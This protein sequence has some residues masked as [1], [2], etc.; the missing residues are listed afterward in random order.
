[1][2][3]AKWLTMNEVRRLLEMP[4]MPNFVDI[5]ED[6]PLSPE[7]FADPRPLLTLGPEI[8]FAGGATIFR[9]ERL[10]FVKCCLELSRI[11]GIDAVIIGYRLSKLCQLMPNNLFD[12]YIIARNQINLRLFDADYA[13]VILGRPDRNAEPGTMPPLKDDELKLLINLAKMV[14]IEIDLLAQRMQ[15]LVVSSGFSFFACTEF[16]ITQIQGGEKEAWAASCALTGRVGGIV[17]QLAP[18]IELPSGKRTTW[19][20]QLLSRD[21]DVYPL[22]DLAYPDRVFYTRAFLK[23]KPF[24]LGPLIRSEETLE[25][26]LDPDQNGPWYR[27]LA[28]DGEVIEFGLIGWQARADARP[29]LDGRDALIRLSELRKD[30][31]QRSGQR[32]GWPDMIR[33]TQKFAEAMNDVVLVVGELNGEVVN[34]VMFDELILR[35]DPQATPEDQSSLVRRDGRWPNVLRI[36]FTAKDSIAL[37]EE[38]SRQLGVVTMALIQVRPNARAPPA[39]VRGPG[40]LL[41]ELPP[42]FT[43]TIDEKAEMLSGDSQ[44]MGRVLSRE[45]F[46]VEFGP[47]GNGVVYVQESLVYDRIKLAR[48]ELFVPSLAPWIISLKSRRR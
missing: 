2:D 31:R 6:P 3:K 15:T 41:W 17:N 20:R 16:A 44:E 24:P 34:W 32:R 11:T 40:G 21:V 48:P 38:R 4:D 22:P 23:D 10:E 5:R 13:R 27:P 39:T 29:T 35:G 28:Q 1:M 36:E 18:V 25:I 12:C 14:N 26:Q 33:A 19:L 37:Y 30:E 45:P 42:A 7:D 8:I 47:E 46:A 43:I 9:E